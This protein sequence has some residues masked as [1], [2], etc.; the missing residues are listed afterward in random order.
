M[1]ILIA[2][3]ISSAF[4]VGC[5]QKLVYD[6]P[7]MDYQECLEKYGSDSPECEEQ[8]KAFGQQREEMPPIDNSAGDPDPGNYGPNEDPGY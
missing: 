8:R 2:I 5:S 1:K 3:I 4:F 7:G 6:S